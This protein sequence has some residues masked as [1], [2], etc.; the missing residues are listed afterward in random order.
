MSESQIGHQLRAVSS[1]PWAAVTVS[2]H[3]DAESVKDLIS[4]DPIQAMK[5]TLPL[6]WLVTLPSA[7][8][9]TGAQLPEAFG[10]VTR[11]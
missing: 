3:Q 10:L 6:P 2:Q 1:I 5:T 11:Y 9:P 4:L 8:C 7:W